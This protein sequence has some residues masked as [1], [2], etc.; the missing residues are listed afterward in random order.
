M[1][2]KE[3]KNLVGS[4]WEWV[5]GH[6]LEFAAL[7]F[8]ATRTFDIVQATAP[9]AWLPWA[10]IG[11]MEGGYIF[12]KGRLSDAKTANQRNTAVVASISTWVVIML[13]ICADAVWQASLHQFFAIGSMPPWA[14]TVAVYAISGIAAI[15]VLLFW[16]Y[17]Y[18]DPDQQL[19]RDYLRMRR[20]IDQDQKRA[21]LD[22][23][24]AEMEAR[25]R[26][27]KR[28]MSKAG[29]VF[30]EAQFREDFQRRFGVYPEDLDR[31]SL[32]AAAGTVKVDGA[33]GSNGKVAGST[34]LNV[35]AGR[36][37]YNADVPVVANPTRQRKA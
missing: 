29:Q 12:W 16:F 9:A 17:D 34:P 22:M 7:V 19:K 30:G 32:A 1:D 8:S 21:L 18:S 5:R 35:D 13:T 4:V 25:V 2:A 11:I 37:N 24:Q 28:V 23:Q 15:H 20:T 10:G 3:E 33:A 6:W 27:W 36:Q 14:S 31:P 26:G